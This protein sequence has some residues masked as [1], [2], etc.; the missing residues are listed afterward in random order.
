MFRRLSTT[1][2]LLV[3]F[4]VPTVAQADL[5]SIYVSGKTGYINGN[6]DAYDHLDSGLG[7]GAEAG[8][9]L[10]G[11][12]IWADALKM[13][14][15][16]F[17]FTANL[18]FDARFGDKWRL[19]LGF[20][21]GPALFMRPEVESEPFALSGTLRSA[22]NTAGIDPT[23]VENEYNDAK[24]DEDQLKRYALGW[25]LARTRLEF[26]RQLVP[27]VFLGIGAQ[28]SYHYMFTGEDAA[29]DAKHT[30]ANDLDQRY[31]INQMDPNLSQNLRSELGAKEL[32]VSSMAGFNYSF[33]AYL[34][35]EI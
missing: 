19:N 22:L 17:Y 14:H 7:N 35:I 26:E 10:L 4:V 20:F 11:I 25:N 12:D 13:G 18:G 5:F 8:I 15:E 23:M 21:T 33:S 28:A 6:G 29:S 34:K 32:D 3:C 9:E 31:G 2:A 24:S 1:I 16:Q 27:L 30:I